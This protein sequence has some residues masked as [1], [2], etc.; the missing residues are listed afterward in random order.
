[1]S[2]PRMGPLYR[3]AVF[4][5]AR[6]RLFNRIW[7]AAF[8]LEARRDGLPHQCVAAWRVCAYG[9]AGHYRE[10]LPWKK[11]R[12]RARRS[13]EQEAL[14]AGADFVRRTSREFGD[15]DSAAHRIF[16]DSRLSVPEIFG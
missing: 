15:A 1:D 7:A 14:A 16:L 13:D 9:G 5:R 6:G 11:S 12:R 3:R 8:W 4:W 2:G 10:L